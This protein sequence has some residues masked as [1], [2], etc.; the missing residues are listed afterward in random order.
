M[1]SGAGFSPAGTSQAR[2]AS[3]SAT[4]AESP[5]RRACGAWA[6]TRLSASD[7]STPRFEVTSECSSSRMMHVKI[8]QHVRRTRIGD[9]Q[10]NLF[11]RGDQNVG[12]LLALALALGMRR[13]AGARLDRD[14]QRH[15]ANR[16]FQIARDIDGQRLER[17]DI[18]RVNAA[19]A[20]AVLGQFD[21]ARQESGQRLAAAGGRDQQHA[22]ALRRVVQDGQL[23]RPRRP[24]ARRKPVEKN[25]RQ[26]AHRRQ[27][28]L[29]GRTTQLAPCPFPPALPV[30]HRSVLAIAVPIMLSNV[31][32]PLIGVVNTA[33]IGQLPDPYYIGAIA[34][35]ALIFSFIFWGF[36]F[37]RLSHRRPVGA[38]RRAPAMRPKWRPC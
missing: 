10:R 15:L 28:D 30:T 33:V 6:L 29:R 32:E 13:V 8:A 11:R 38:G 27:L 17:R 31:S 26:K 9:Q 5:M 35:G 34:V 2:S 12:R 21:E 14:G 1:T 23:M 3:G 16:R 22:L 20:R 37:L 36:G 18:K 4:V 19:G 24:A 7:S 25:L